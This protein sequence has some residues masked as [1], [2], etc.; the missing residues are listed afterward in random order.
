MIINMN[1]EYIFNNE[2][3]KMNVILHL[4]NIKNSYCLRKFKIKN[5]IP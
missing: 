2:C 5:Y 3:T 1:N 4:C